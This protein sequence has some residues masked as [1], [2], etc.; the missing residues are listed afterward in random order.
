MKYDGIR[1]L[2]YVDD[3]LRLESRNGNDITVAWPEL[4]ALAP[5]RPGFVVD[6]EIVVE[7][8]GRSSFTALA[9][10]MHQRNPAA[11]R[12]LA[13]STP[14]TFMIFDLLHIGE[15]SLIELPYER[16]RE[17][18]ESTGLGGAHW[19]IPHPLPGTGAEALADSQSLGLEG[20]V[21]KRRDSRYVPGQRSPAWIKVKNFRH[22]EV[23]IIGW[24]RG[25]GRRAGQIGSLL[26][27]VPDDRGS[28]EYAGSVGTGFTRAVLTDLAERLTALRRPDPPIPGLARTPPGVTWV[29]PKYVGEV[30]FTEWTG[31]GHLRHPSWR[32]LRLDKD[33][34]EI[35]TP[36]GRP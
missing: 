7:D 6:G 26:L 27:A 25:T 2:A 34:D 30:A 24:K 21:C 12:E 29:W 11:I 1:A 22:Q 18:L 17:L 10:R 33:L 35:E 28:L 9:P 8:A 5:A 15:H 32:G 19:Q 20:I 31:D 16:R 3:G 13:E 14:A 23:A 36:T 4:A